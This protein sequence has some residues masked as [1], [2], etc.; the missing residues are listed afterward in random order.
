[1]VL[2]IVTCF[3]SINYYCSVF[4]Y[5]HDVYLLSFNTRQYVGKADFLVFRAMNQHGFL[6]Q[7][8]EKKLVSHVKGFHC[9][10]YFYFNILKVMT[11]EPRRLSLKIIKKESLFTKHICVFFPTLALCP[12]MYVLQ[13]TYL[14]KHYGMMCCLHSV[15]FIN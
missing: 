13:G 3:V 12:Q 7:L 5:G 15:V 11:Y 6:G 14:H 10:N 2:I 8:Q 4:Y 9:V 1:M